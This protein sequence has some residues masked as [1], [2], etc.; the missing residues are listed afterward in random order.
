MTY[1]TSLYLACDKIPLVQIG[2]PFTERVK[3]LFVLF[4]NISE[5]GR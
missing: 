5:V 3:Q 1:H 2:T 4:L